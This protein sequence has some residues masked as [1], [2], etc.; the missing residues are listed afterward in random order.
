MSAYCNGKALLVNTMLLY[1]CALF[2]ASLGAE[3]LTVKVRS[4]SA[5]LIN[6]DSGAVLYQKHPHKS[7]YPASITKIAT[8]LYALEQQNLDSDVLVTAQQD[9]VGWVSPQKKKKSKYTLPAYWLEPGAMHIGIKVGERVPIRDLL[10][11][12]LLASGDECSNMIAHHVGG[13]V[14]TFM[15]GLNRYLQEEVGC[16]HT[17]FANPHGLFHP[18]QK[19][20]A[21]DM[22]LIAQRAMRHPLFRS[23]VASKEY[24][25]APTNKAKAVKIRQTNRLLRPGKYHYPKAIGIKTGYIAKAKNTLVAAAKDQDRTLIAVLLRCEDRGDI[26]QDA[27]RLFNAAMGEDKLRREFFSAGPQRFSRKLDNGQTLTTFTTEPACVQYYS[28]EEPTI[29]CYLH[30]DPI[31]TPVVKGQQV[32]RLELTDTTGDV[33]NTVALYAQNDASDGWQGWMI[34]VF[35]SPGWGSALV[36]TVAVLCVLIL[37]GGFA[38]QLR[39]RP[40]KPSE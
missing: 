29:R 2:H 20:T 26:F 35:A 9:L 32:G 16:T 19:T 14:D 31:K 27:I 3:Q 18:D 34:R 8:A 7:H 37:F 30:W 38:M 13:S 12:M 4:Q 17:H 40:K 6:A 24:R 28:G 22:A 10:Y 33:L 1:L 21:M 15:Q 5:V 25:K 36:E 11:G 39:K 23:V